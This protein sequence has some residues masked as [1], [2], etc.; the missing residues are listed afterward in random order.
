MLLIDSY[1]ELKIYSTKYMINVFYLHR[2]GRVAQNKYQNYL[3]DK[4]NWNF[5][6]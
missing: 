6:K 1:F 2:Y 5:N 3:T 4:L